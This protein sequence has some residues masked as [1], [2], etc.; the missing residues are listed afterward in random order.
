VAF[1]DSTGNRSGP[2]ASFSLGAILITA[3]CFQG[4]GSALITPAA[5]SILTRAPDPGDRR[6]V[7]IRAT[8]QAIQ[9]VWVEIY[10]PL[11]TEGFDDIAHYT[12]RPSGPVPHDVGRSGSTP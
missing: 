4:L 11:V 6:K 7:I 2:G 3:R 8:R 12:A 10:Q 9:K 5:L 1:P